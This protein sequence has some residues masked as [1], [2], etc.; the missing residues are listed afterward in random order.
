MTF[1]LPSGIKR[2]SLIIQIMLIFFTERKSLI[3]TH[4]KN[5][6]FRPR[7]MLP[8]ILILYFHISF[9][10]AIVTE[11]SNHGRSLSKTDLLSR[12][13]GLFKALSSIYHGAFLR[14]NSFIIV[15]L[16]GSR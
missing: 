5:E 13:R 3:R 1:L 4:L 14:Q 10:Y 11:Q 8:F 12:K 15:A 16:Q 2:L 7:K 6:V 9:N